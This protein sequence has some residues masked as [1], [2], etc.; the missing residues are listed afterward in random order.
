VGEPRSY[1]DL[2]KN[3]VIFWPAELA[4]K[5]HA[6]SIIPLLLASQDKFI[7]LLHVADSSPTCWKDLLAK[8]AGFPGNLFLKHLVVLADVGGEQLKRFSTELVRVFRKGQMDYAWNGRGYAHR[9]RTLRGGRWDNKSL[10]I[11]GAGLVESAPLSPAMEDICMLVMFGGA[12]TNP[13]LPP[14]IAERCTIG[15]LLGKKA[16]LDTFV[17]QRYIW[18]SRITGGATQNAMGHLVQACVRERLQQL[19]PG[20]SF[21]KSKI[22]GTSQN[23]GRTDIAFDFVAESPKRT[24]CAIEVSFQVTTNST[25]ERKAGQAQ[26]RQV[27]LHGNGHYI[28][29]VI[30]GAGNFERRSALATICRYS[31][32]TVAFSAHELGRLAEFLKSIG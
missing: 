30:D 4:E 19:L 3:A 2:K 6:A 5:E 31:D 25:I 9:F 7:S 12:A 24:Y 32:C 8:T 16:E 10:R 23:A 13:G 22:P 15:Q 20:W 29:Y 21:R 18:V 26:A 28:A 11:D 14:V 17:R 27:L 1:D